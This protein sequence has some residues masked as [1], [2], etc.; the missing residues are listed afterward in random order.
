MRRG[1]TIQSAFAVVTISLVI[2]G[3]IAWGQDT[4]NEEL[5]GADKQL[6]AT[7]Q[8]VLRRLRPSDQAAFRK[9][10]RAWIAFR[11]A[12]CAF[13]DADRRDCLIQRTDERER[14]LRDTTYFDAQGQVF[15]LP[16][17]RN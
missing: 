5:A 6:N 14:Q 9:A 16:S 7:Y 4:R 1:V 3:S 15:L 17:R 13:G 8:E 11:D 10:Q 12:D 2:G